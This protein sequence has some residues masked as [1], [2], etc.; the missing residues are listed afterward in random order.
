MMEIA[1]T[2]DPNKIEFADFP[3]KLKSGLVAEN[4]VW[5]QAIEQMVSEMPDGIRFVQ[6]LLPMLADAMKSCEILRVMTGR[7]VDKYNKVPWFDTFSAT[8]ASLYRF[9]VIIKDI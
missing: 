6:P 4:F 3:L 2:A 8:F 7:I 1:T 9:L 5:D